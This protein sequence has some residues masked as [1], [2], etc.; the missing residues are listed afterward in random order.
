MTNAEILGFV[1]TVEELGELTGNNKFRFALI[2]N[3]RRLKGELEDYQETLS[4]ITDKHAK[5]DDDGNIIED[6]DSP[7]GVAIEDAEAFNRELNELLGEEV[8]VDVHSV[9]I[10]HVPED[11]TLNQLQALEVMIE[12][13]E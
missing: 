8:D 3:K 6:E 1:N 4:G 11:I 13:F 7:V 12:G 10:K 5:T 9:D 2:K